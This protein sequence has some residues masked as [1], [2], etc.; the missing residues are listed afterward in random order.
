[1]TYFPRLGL[2][3]QTEDPLPTCRH[4]NYDP[5]PPPAPPTPCSAWTAVTSSGGAEY[6]KRGG[7]VA[8]LLRQG[9]YPARPQTLSCKPSYRRHVTRIV[10]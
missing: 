8:A 2:L 6:A 9:M 3:L 5:P 4:H 10:R 1:M 7:E